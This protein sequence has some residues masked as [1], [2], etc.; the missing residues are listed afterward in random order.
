MNECK[1]GQ[2]EGTIPYQKAAALLGITPKQMAGRIW[3]DSVGKGDP[4][5]CKVCGYVYTDT[6]RN[7]DDSSVVQPCK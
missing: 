6:L 4:V 3:R 1:H 2:V 5:G 7:A